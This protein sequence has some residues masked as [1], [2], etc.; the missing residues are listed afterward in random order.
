MPEITKEEFESILTHIQNNIKKELMYFFDKD[1]EYAIKLLKWQLEVVVK[2]SLIHSNSKRERADKDRKR[3][4]WVDYG[5]NI[6][7]EF[8]YPHFCVVIKQFDNTAIVVPL[9]TVKEHNAD[10]KSAENLVIEI[11]SIEGLPREQKPCFAMVNQIR[12]IS[13]QR[14]TEYRESK[15]SP[16]VKLK[17]TD[18]Q[19]N[20][21]DEAIKSLAKK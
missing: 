11:G 14:L 16:F 9:S 17:L 15:S 12:S 2:N 6:G 1:Q 3:V 7:S 4:Y 5:V 19:M 13:K 8:N 18:P 20:L 21:I 10:W